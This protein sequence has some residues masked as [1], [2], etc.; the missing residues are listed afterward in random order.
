M[1]SGVPE[2]T[3]EVWVTLPEH[4]PSREVTVHVAETPDPERVPTQSPEYPVP[5]VAVYR[6]EPTLWTTSRACISAVG[7]AGEPPGLV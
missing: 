4:F 7:A 3:V 5:F 1:V 2:V 6:T